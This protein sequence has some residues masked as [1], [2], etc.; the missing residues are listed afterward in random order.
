M[1]L[2]ELILSF[3]NYVCAQYLTM[4]STKRTDKKN[5]AGGIKFLILVPMIACAAAF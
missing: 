4:C 1:Y 2:T 3:P 5:G